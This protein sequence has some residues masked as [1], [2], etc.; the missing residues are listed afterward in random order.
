MAA[1]TDAKLITHSKHHNNKTT[2]TTTLVLSK[3]PTLTMS[4]SMAMWSVSAIRVRTLTASSR[5]ATRGLTRRL[6]CLVSSARFLTGSSTN[7]KD[8]EGG[9]SA[10]T[11]AQE[12]LSATEWIPP[13]RPLPGD[14]GQYKATQEQAVGSAEYD[15]DDE[16]EEVEEEDDD[17]DDIDYDMIDED[18][19]EFDDDDEDGDV[20]WFDNSEKIQEL[21][22][23]L[24]Q[25]RRQQQEQS[26]TVSNSS[27]GVDWMKA[28]RKRGIDMMTPDL[29]DKKRREVSDLPVLHRT[30]LS[31]KEIQTCLEALGGI[32]LNII[33]EEPGK[34][35]GPEVQGLVFCTAPT[36][37]QLRQMSFALVK[38]LQ[39]RD[40]DKVGV[41]G[42]KHGAEG[43]D[44]PDSEW[45]VLDCRNYIVHIQSE[46][47]RKYMDI[48][49]IWTGKDKFF[50][51]DYNDEDAVEEY[52]S[53]GPAHDL[54]ENK[55]DMDQTMSRLQRWNLDHKSVVDR[56]RMKKKNRKNSGRRGW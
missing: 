51:L 3:E 5:I 6:P 53:T 25:Q 56:P 26:G 2:T 27:I 50:K 46:R 52:M 43:R 55:V 22:E 17:D 30:L 31:A 54:E 32:D 49:A 39:R 14:K 33:R 28:R 4:A 9:A 23:I 20:P 11:T 12:D 1:Q 15:D 42:A 34:R 21:E 29:A 36:T 38:Q 19:I 24:E 44:D 41:I 8:S 18:D 45:H 48:E 16:E 7:D 40:L 10:T 37:R 47:M 35:L 13:N